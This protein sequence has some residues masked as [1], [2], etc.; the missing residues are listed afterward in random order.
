MTTYGSAQFK[1]ISLLDPLEGQAPQQAPPASRDYQIYA[2]ELGLSATGVA[3]KKNAYWPNANVIGGIPAEDPVLA[4]V[5]NALTRL[6]IQEKRLAVIQE[7][8]SKLSEKLTAILEQL[9][10]VAGFRAFSVQLETLAPEPYRLIRPISVL[11]EG[12][13]E[14]FTAS[15]LQANISGSG[16]TEADALESLRDAIV[17]TYEAL[18][19]VPD[20]D[21]GPLPI[22]QKNTLMATVRRVD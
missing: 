16:E 12:N 17:S 20:D 14:D 2:V 21:L 19:D 1:E 18:S 8:Q 22:R 7:N 3:K 9:H 4:A 15:F 10:N 13:G 6:A 5:N 11:V